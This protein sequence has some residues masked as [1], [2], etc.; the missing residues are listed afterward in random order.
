MPTPTYLVR[1]FRPSNT[2]DRW[3][4]ALYSKRGCKYPRP[5]YVQKSGH[6]SANTLARAAES[7]RDLFGTN[8]R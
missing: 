3:E 6:G 1:V 7:V 8:S 4:I 2:G 5:E